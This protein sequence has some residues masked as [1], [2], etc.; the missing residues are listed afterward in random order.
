MILE[1]NNTTGN[2]NGMSICDGG[3]HY[4]RDTAESLAQPSDDVAFTLLSDSTDGEVMKLVEG[5]NAGRKESPLQQLHNLSSQH[6]GMSMDRSHGMSLCDGGVHYARETAESLLPDSTD[7]EV[8]KLVEGTYAGRE[9]SALQQL[10]NLSSQDCGMSIDKPSQDLGEQTTQRY[11]T[12]RS[13][14]EI[15]SRRLHALKRRKLMDS[16]RPLQREA[17]KFIENAEHHSIIIMPT[18]S[19]KTT[20]IWSYKHENKCSLVFAPFKI[21]VHQ[22]GSVLAKKGKVAAFPLVS[23]D[24][25]LFSILATYDFIILPYEAAPSSADLVSSLN[26]LDRLGPI[27]V[28]EVHNLATTGRFRISLDSFWN[29][30]AELQIR[31]VDHIMIGLTATLRPDDVSDVMRRMSIASADVYRQS[32]FRPELD[33]RFLRFNQERIVITKACLMATDFA[34]EGKVLVFTSTVSLCDAIGD[35]IQTSFG[36]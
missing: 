2:S 19:G 28:D 15:E 7:G 31:K 8:M 6:C 25:D 34:K 23:N 27:W 16:L 30:S 12:M 18:G 22:L 11:K 14:A 36:W 13:L 24:G 20:L 4:A 9:G 10:H 17:L 35:Q 21:L 26:D 32:C 3:V 1:V 5:T 29:L 33:I